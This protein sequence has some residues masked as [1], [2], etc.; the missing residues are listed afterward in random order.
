MA[1]RNTRIVVAF[2]RPPV[3]VFQTVAADDIHPNILTIAI[4]PNEGF[5]YSFEVKAPG[6]DVQ[7]K[8]ER[9]RFRY[10]EAFGPLPE[11]Y[12]TLLLDV[13]MGD[14]TLFVRADEVEAAWR[15]YAPVLDRPP[16]IVHYPA[17]SWGPAQADRLLTNEGEVWLPA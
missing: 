14:Q 10:A 12:E 2:R 16:K 7:L 17:G 15:L 9:L 13:I 4:Q 3:S 8:T 5:D 11:A 1:K 6:Q